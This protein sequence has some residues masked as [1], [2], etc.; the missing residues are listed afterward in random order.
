MWA[1]ARDAAL[2][3]QREQGAERSRNARDRGANNAN[4]RRHE[5]QRGAAL[6]H[7]AAESA[8]RDAAAGMRR[9]ARAQ[10]PPQ[11]DAPELHG[12]G[13]ISTDDMQGELWRGT[14]EKDVA[15]PPRRWREGGM[16]F[17]SAK[18]DETPRGRE[19]DPRAKWA[20]FEPAPHIFV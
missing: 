14:D 4:R 9:R 20:K 13:W 19:H 12:G 11:G 15:R 6:P 16:K 2:A 10:V 5:A 18:R 3:R 8:G 1:R 7:A 17:G